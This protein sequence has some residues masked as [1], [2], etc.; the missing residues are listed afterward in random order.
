VLGLVPQE[1]NGKISGTAKPSTRQTLMLS[2]GQE[3]YLSAFASPQMN[4]GMLQVYSPLYPTPDKCD[5]AQPGSLGLCLFTYRVDAIAAFH[6]QVNCSVA[7]NVTPIIPNEFGEPSFG[8]FAPDGMY[9]VIV[10]H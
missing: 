9:W 7:T 1:W 3:F 2:E 8:F 10:G 4:V 6:Q 5:Y